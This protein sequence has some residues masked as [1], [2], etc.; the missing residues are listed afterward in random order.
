MT[1]RQPNVGGWSP[2]RLQLSLFIRDFLMEN[3]VTWAYAIY[4]GYRQAMK[5]ETTHRGKRKRKAISYAA[6]SNY[7]Y[8]FRRLD[9]VEYVLDEK[10]EQITED[11]A[12]GNV[13]DEPWVDDEDAGTRGGAKRTMI[14]I[15]AGKE[16]DPAW[17][18]PRRALYG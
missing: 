11:P 17:S 15:V 4:N 16:S 14:R 13:P 12:R 5:E 1:Q 10:G 18:N 3:P 8:M 6:F 9:M 2:G 7:M